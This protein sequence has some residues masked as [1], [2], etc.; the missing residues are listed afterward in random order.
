MFSID[1]ETGPYPMPPGQEGA[2]A[3][4]PYRDEFYMKM[5]GVAGANDYGKAIHMDGDNFHNDII[6]ELKHMAGH[7]VYCHNAIFDIAVLLRRVGTAEN[8]LANIK[9]RDTG[10][11][12]KWLYNTAK[13]EHFRYSLRNCVEKWLPDSD[14]KE[15]FLQMKDNI[16]DEYAYWLE[17]VVQ[18]CHMTR[19][20]AVELE[21]LLPDEQR[22]GYIVEC[23]CLYPLAR[24]WM[25]GIKIDYDVV[26]EARIIYQAKANKLL[27]EIG[28][29]ETTLRSPKKLGA[30]LFDTWGLEPISHTKTGAPSTCADDIKY[31]ALKSGDPRIG[32]LV[33][34]KQALTVISKYVNGFNKAKA[35]LNS[36]KIHPSPRLFNSYTGRMTY[37]SKL[38]KKYQVGIAL[39]QLPRKAKEIKRA[40][41]APPGY[42]FLYMDFAAQELRIMAQFSND[43][44]MLNAFNEGQD[45]HAVMTE[46]IYGTSYK[47]VVAGNIDNI[48]EIVDQRNCGKLTNLSS[49]YRIGAKSLQAKFFTQYDKVINLREATHFLNSYKKAFRGIPSYWESSIKFAR[50]YGYAASLSDRRFQV[51]ATDWKGESSAINMPIQGSGADLSEIAIASLARQFPNM[52]FQIQVHDSMTWLIPENDDPQ[53]VKEYMNNFDFN[54]FFRAGLNLNFPLDFAYGDSLGTLE[55][56]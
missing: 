10:L 54:K 2:Y 25:Q 28:T 18:D 40:M 44:V 20:L 32:K 47:T 13:D 56:L 26:D 6:T 51:V 48:P 15:Q 46:K 11:L 43:K 7:E 23:A 19:D 29:T 38:F 22:G 14:A 1:T 33:E 9:W 53:E 3:L 37:S 8:L 24:G 27:R 55:T 36:D 41:V 17:R 50:K 42:K 4:E 45:L 35:Y 39:H 21:R 34:A 12:A 52:I 49:M 16:E 5:L 30:L 31:I